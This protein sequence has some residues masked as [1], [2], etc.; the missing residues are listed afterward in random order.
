[1]QNEKTDLNKT[2]QVLITIWAVI[3]FSQF[4]FVL[5]LFVVKRELFN[6]D[7]TQPIAGREPVMTAALALLGITSF[8]VSFIW[9][10]RFIKRS[11]IEQKIGLVQSGML[12]GI[13]LSDAVTL[14]GLMT[15][16][17]YDYPYFFL[18]IGLGILGALLHFPKRED[19]M[20]ASFKR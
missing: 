12:V 20:A 9:R 16:F 6:F 8:L 7:F 4:I 17:L 15:A 10:A 13:A 3:L 5:V 14:F 11:V 19:L 18:F 1:M 2:Y